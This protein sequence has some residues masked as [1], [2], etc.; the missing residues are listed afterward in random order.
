MTLTPEALARVIDHTL[1]QFDPAEDAD[2]QRRRI[3]ALCR[4]AT[5]EGF[6]AVCVRPVHA[7]IARRAL[8]ALQSSA[9]LAVVIAFPS[10]RAALRRE[11]A[12][13]TFG[14]AATADKLAEIAQA[15]ADG[16]DEL[17][18][19]MNL[20]LFQRERA[21]S[22]WTQTAREWRAL[23]Q[24]AAGRPVKLILETDWHNPDDIAPLCRLA[25]ECGVAMVKTSTGMAIDAPGATPDIIARMGAALAGQSRS[26]G[27]KASG[28][29]RSAAQ[30]LA[31]L[32]AGATRLGT[33]AGPHLLAQLR[34]NASTEAITAAY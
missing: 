11:C 24:A 19:V 7:A 21:E 29:V 5:R 27:V 15:L 16:A 22:E 8:D 25:A 1:L 13:P 14:G 32:Q 4:E 12:H 2:A 31:L 33:S 9:H 28:G 3:E 10:E 18:I 23:T 30:A 20:A 6:A 26:V 34:A 17:D